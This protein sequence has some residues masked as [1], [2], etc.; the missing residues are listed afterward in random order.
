M[1]QSSLE[2]PKQASLHQDIL[3][4]SDLHL[5]WEKP[6]LTRRFLDFLQYRAS[7]AQAVY[8]LGDL[9]DAWIGDDDKTPPNRS[10]K[11]ALRALTEAGIRIFLLQ[12]N[13]D[14]LLGEQFCRETGIALLDDYSV[15]DLNG[16]RVLLTHG[17]LLCTDDEAY[18]AFRKK[19]RNPRWRNN[20]LSKPLIL[21]LLAARWYRLRSFYH[22]RGKTDEIMDVNQQTV[23][24]T[25]RQ[26]GCDILIHGHTHRPNLHEFLLEGRHA[27]RFVLADWTMDGASA[28]CWNGSSF[29]Q[30]RL[31]P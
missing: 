14:F 28:L 7:R 17:D 23:A 26:H 15:I 9:F 29:Q 19:S 12:G 21:R 8:I 27:K 24:E 25:M 18:Q 4:I 20:V 22:K 30:E 3:F 11:K 13:R 10:I 1:P 5:A 2:T 31:Y 6:G 16:T